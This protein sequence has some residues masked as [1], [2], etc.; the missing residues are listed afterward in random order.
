MHRCKSSGNRPSAF[1]CQP[2]LHCWPFDSVNNRAVVNDASARSD[3]EGDERVCSVGRP[4]EGEHGRKGELRHRLLR[5]ER[6]IF[7]RNGVNKRQT[8]NKKATT[9]VDKL[10]AILATHVGQSNSYFVYLKEDTFVN[11]EIH[12]LKFDKI[13]CVLK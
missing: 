9:T 12:Q 7:G 13:K 3:R 4:H 8:K 1:S 10:D 2:P 6:R 11:C 5:P